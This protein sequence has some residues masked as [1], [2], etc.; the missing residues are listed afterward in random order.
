MKKIV[1][2][3]ILAL[4]LSLSIQAVNAAPTS[5]SAPTSTSTPQ[6][7]EK[8]IPVVKVT[9]ASKKI[10]F[11]YVNKDGEIVCLNKKSDSTSNTLAK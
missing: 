4:G 8:R 6:T 3:S 1:T 9:C 10:D 2:C 11:Y 5:A 7:K